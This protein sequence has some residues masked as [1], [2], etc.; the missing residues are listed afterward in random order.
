MKTFFISDINLQHTSCLIHF[1]ALGASFLD[2]SLLN[3]HHFSDIFQASREL[4][5]A[6]SVRKKLSLLAEAIS[7]IR[8]ADI[9]GNNQAS[10]LAH[11]HVINS[12]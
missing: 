11:S 5:E 10:F 1:L 2:N 8:P 12:F 6:V 9:M 7:F 4:S 3:N